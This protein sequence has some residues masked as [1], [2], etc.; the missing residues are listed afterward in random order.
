MWVTSMPQVWDEEGVP[1][2]GAADA[3][4][5]APAAAMLSSLAGWLSRTVQPQPP[6]PRVCGTDGGPPV[7]APRLRL[8]DGRHLAYC[9]TG[10]PK[11]KARFRV[12][13]SHGFTGSREDTVRPSQVTNY[14]LLNN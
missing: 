6:P 12:V 10:V 14:H 11:D 2:R 3:V 9:E 7:T 8:R 1:K 13:F 5:P 4:T